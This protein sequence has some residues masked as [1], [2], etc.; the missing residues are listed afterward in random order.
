[1]GTLFAFVLVCAGVL[2][3]QNA[4]DRPQGKFRTPYIN[5]KFIMPLLFILSVVLLFAYGQDWLN[6][7]VSYGEW[8]SFKDKIPLW[9]FLILCFVMTFFSFTKNLS[10]I[11]TLGLIF[12]FYMMAQI[13][14]SSWFGFFIWLIAGLIIY[15]LFGIRNSKLALRHKTTEKM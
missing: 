4:P 14:L 12:C 2:K 10:L 9:L 1:M 13:P 8:N 3:L 7:F 11:P 6:S 5:G 15:F